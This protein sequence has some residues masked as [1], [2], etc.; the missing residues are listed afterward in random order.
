M[1]YRTGILEA[2]QDYGLVLG[3]NLLPYAGWTI[4]GVSTF[5]PKASVNHHTAGAAKGILPSLN[6]LLYGRPGIPG[7]LCNA[8]LDRLARVHLI[9]AGKANHAG[10]GGWRGVSG[11]SNCWGL[12]VE[13]IGLPSEMVTDEQWAAMHKW[14][15]ACCDYSNF[16][17]SMVC[18]HFEWAPARKIDFVKPITDPHLFRRR[19]QDALSNPSGGGFLAALTEKQQQEIYDHI[20]REGR[21]K[22]TTINSRQIGD[23]IKIVNGIKSQPAGYFAET[24]ESLARKTVYYVDMAQQSKVEMPA[25]GDLHKWI[26]SLHHLIGAS[27]TA[28]KLKES[29]LPPAH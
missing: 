27:E 24:P 4:R 9:A 19:V 16:P 15:A 11:N 1:P 29:Q 13:H 26:Q 28:V 8:A 12:E 18:Q 2:C 3:R 25:G 6:V 7:P 23:V 20:C 22:E 14:H 21:L 10:K 5:D 17:S